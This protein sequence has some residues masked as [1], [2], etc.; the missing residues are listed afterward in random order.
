MS[1]LTT[2]ILTTKGGVLVYAL[3][4]LL[5]SLPLAFVGTYLTLDKSRAFPTLGDPEG[6]TVLE[7]PGSVSQRGRSRLPDNVLSW[8]KSVY[9]LE[10]PRA[11]PRFRQMLRSSRRWRRSN[12]WRL[13]GGL[14]GLLTGYLFGVCAP[15]ILT[16]Y[17]TE[18]TS[19]TLTTIPF[20]IIVFLLA[21][22]FSVLGSK[23]HNVAILL[24]CVGGS[25]ALTTFAIFALNCT[26]VIR[27]SL[28]AVLCILLSIIPVASLIT[29][30]DKLYTSLHW[31]LRA[32]QSAFGCMG[33]V[34]SIAVLA[35][36]P[37]WEDALSQ[38]WAESRPDGGST[39]ALSVMGWIL[40]VSGIG[41]DWTLFRTLGPSRD[42]HWDNYL[43]HYLDNLPN[44]A[45]KFERFP[46][47]WSRI[48]SIFHKTHEPLSKSSGSLDD[49]SLPSFDVIPKIRKNKV[50]R[51]PTQ[52][53]RFD[54][55]AGSSEDERIPDNKEITSKVGYSDAVSEG[56]TLLGSGSG[57]PLPGKE[58]KDAYKPGVYEAGDDITSIRISPDVHL[59]YDLNANDEN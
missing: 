48:S 59:M 17:I 4:L 31:S 1:E 37:G 55:A 28:W 5:V 32:S 3:P 42:Q 11:N 9:N 8:E 23:F 58:E 16:L 49:E 25:F 50:S 33:V 27:L 18:H 20:L 6:P 52:A 22:M 19:R 46:S 51:R 54:L 44:R 53:V 14:G 26:P 41:C 12:L 43:A 38:L 57:R 36:V 10:V 13:E 7:L 29:A 2:T 56:S 21:A 39:L 45:G 15:T 24:S 47:L 35:R 34:Y 40:F 30:S